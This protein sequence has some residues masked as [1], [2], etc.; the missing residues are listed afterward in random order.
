MRAGGFAHR[1]STFLLLAAGVTAAVA[2]DRHVYLDTNG[3]GQLN[4][5]P[6]PAHNASGVSSTNELFFC[7][8]GTAAGKVIGTA[9]G[10]V[11]AAACGAA[12]GTVTPLRNGSLA[13]VDGDGTVEAVYGHPQACVWNMRKSD[14]CEVHAGVYRRPGAQ[15]TSACGDFSKAGVPDG[16]CADWNCF[17][18]S[19][20]AYGYGPNLDGTGYGTAAAPGLLRG[21]LMNGA[22]DSWDADGDK[23]ADGQPGE[24]AAWPAVLSGD[25]DG[26]GVFDT[27]A[28]TGSSCSG[29]AFFMVQVGCGAAGTG[30]YGIDCSTGFSATEHGP[31][32]DTDADGVFDTE[33]GR[34]GSREVDHFVIRDLVFTGYNGGNGSTEQTARHKEAHINLNGDGSSNGLVVDHVRI[35]GNDYKATAGSTETF[36]A[37]IADMKNAG[38]VSPH[39]TE[40]KNSFIEQDNQLVFDNDGGIGDRMGCAFNI[41]DNRLL[42]NVT[43][44]RSGQGGPTDA[45]VN[46]IA[47]LKSIDV[48]DDGTP[49]IHR[50]WNNEVIYR[51]GGAGP[52]WFMDVQAFGNSNG[53]GQGEMRVYGNLFRNEPAVVNRL[54]FFFP[55][56]CGGG[57]GSW[58]WLWFNNTWD[59]WSGATSIEMQDVCNS[60]GG[61]LYVGRNNVEVF[62]TNEEITQAT[63][64]IVS[65]DVSTDASRCAGTSPYF[66]CGPAPGLDAGPA[67][68]AA[69]P[70]GGLDGAGSCDPDGDGTPGVDYDGDGVNDTA[71]R[72]L[73]G[74]PVSCAGPAAAMDI[75]AL[76]SVSTDTVPPAEPRNFRRTDVK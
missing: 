63:T 1:L 19:V 61:E 12:G 58:R 67:W 38:C 73:A 8:G 25:V 53:L 22:V 23:V 4:D 43:S 6:N 14:S 72:D 5:C 57:T 20:L 74:T 45:P 13:D 65:N 32:V 75:G 47:Y 39:F 62:T 50:F 64:R 34:Q 69:K 52:S 54:Q 15:C 66:V 76:Q 2:A 21:A 30:S 51:N 40:V 41:H 28:C 26:D 55:I 49:K 9:T 7:A 60:T 46:A 3:D 37:V 27:T 71:W 31:M 48:L 17:L 10:R 35:T 56:F 33:I 44:S 68:Y 16:T 70:G 24:P 11:S 36:W 42:V 59:G 29:D 18:A